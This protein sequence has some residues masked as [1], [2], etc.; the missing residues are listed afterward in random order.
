M[1]I[2]TKT[3]R[4]ALATLLTLIFAGLLGA[5]SV[6]T[7]HGQIYASLA[8]VSK[9][10]VEYSLS[11]TQLSPSLVSPVTNPY[12]LAVNST[13]LFVADFGASKIGSFD[14][15][16]ST[17][18]A[19]FISLGAQPYGVAVSG[20]A[21]YVSLSNG[22]ILKY[23]ATTHVQD[24]GFTATVGNAFFM[25]LDGLGN[26]YIANKAGNAVG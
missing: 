15:A 19:G 11:G 23:D 16:S 2:Q 14:I 25:A 17:Y 7:A 13:T 8:D 20:N 3:P 4:S 26:L 6:N 10:V 18:T 24:S 12:G 21:L 9:K 1:K 5:L 22:S